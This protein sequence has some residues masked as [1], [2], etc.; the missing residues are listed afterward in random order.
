MKCEVVGPAA[1][2]AGAFVMG[3]LTGNVESATKSLTK[4][5]FMDV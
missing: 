4:D 3:L 2:K 5:D 1:K